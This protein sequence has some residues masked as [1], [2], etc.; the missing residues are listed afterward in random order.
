MNLKNFIR[1]RFGFKSKSKVVGEGR[2]RC[3]SI[4]VPVVSNLIKLRPD[5]EYELCDLSSGHFTPTV[6][7]LLKSFGSKF[8]EQKFLN[9]MPPN[10]FSKFDERL[11]E[12]SRRPYS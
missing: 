11:L 6:D 1:S 2:Y 9:V 3:Y 5:F 12:T 8:D 10:D 7:R 4:S